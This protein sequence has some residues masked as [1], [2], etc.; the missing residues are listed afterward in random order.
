M[1]RGGRQPGSGRKPGFTHSELTRQRIRTTVL[2]NRLQK[3]ALGE[4]K[5]PM[6]PSQVAA[7]L[8]LLAKTLPDLKAIEY[9]G[10]VEHTVYMASGE[11]MSEE[12]WE[13]AYGGRRR[14]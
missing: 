3:F 8:G 9:S 11:P 7:A 2:L 12:D 13:A 10:E 14:N 4:L 1:R 5:R 6:E